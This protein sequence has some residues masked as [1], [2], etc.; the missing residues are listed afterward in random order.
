MITDNLR[1]WIVSQIDTELGSGSGDFGLGGNSTNPSSVGLDVP[2]SQSANITLTK[3]STENV[4]EVKLTMNNAGSYIAG[5]VLREAGIFDSSSDLWLRES[6]EGIGSF[7][8][9]ETVE[10][11]FILEVE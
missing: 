10:I 7:S 11:I 3:A 1:D 4:F 8:T 6:F 2:L 9:T 5:K